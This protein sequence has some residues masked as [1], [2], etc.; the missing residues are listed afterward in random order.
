MTKRLSILLAAALM[1]SSCAK[2]VVKP[3]YVPLTFMPAIS[4]N[5]K[6]FM[7]SYPLSSSFA[8]WAYS[9]PDGKV[10]TSDK[11]SRQTIVENAPVK[12]YDGV[13]TAAAMP[14]LGSQNT[15]FFACSP[16]GYKGFE[17]DVNKGIQVR[18]Y[19]LVEDG[20]DIL[21]S[22][23]ILDQ[24]SAK[25]GGQ[26]PVQFYHALSEVTFK[27]RSA[28]PTEYIMKVRKIILKGM[29]CRGNFESLPVA[30]WFGTDDKRDIE[31]SRNSVELTQ[32]PKL[33]D[34]KL[35]I[36]QSPDAHVTV[37]VDMIDRATGRPY[38]IEHELTAAKTLQLFKVGKS[39]TYILN[40]SLTDVTFDTDPIK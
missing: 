27:A 24:N 10:W 11:A 17:F 35:V 21:F 16:F 39:Y 2:T 9:V 6:D 33:I 19:S 1:L 4:V 30:G 34:T 31:F 12:Y 29:D 22:D 14:E 26:I 23:P 5:T 25:T 3:H 36:P 38:L 37:V 32:S 28:A 40:V 20:T 7:G 18:N 8:I 15:T 13:W